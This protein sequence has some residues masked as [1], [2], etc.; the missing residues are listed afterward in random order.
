VL[1]LFLS[2][3]QKVQHPVKDAAPCNFFQDKVL[4]AHFIE[5]F[6]ISVMSSGFKSIYPAG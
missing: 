6:S 3:N 5:A 4:F 1:F 2:L